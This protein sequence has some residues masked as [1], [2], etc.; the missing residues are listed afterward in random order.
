VVCFGVLGLFSNDLLEGSSGLV[1]VAALEQCDAVGERVALE[2]GAVERPREGERLFHSLGC[3]CRNLCR[4]LCK[5]SWI[6]GALVELH[7]HSGLVDQKRAGQRQIAAPVKKI[8]IKNV[9]DPGDFWCSEQR[10]QVDM[11]PLQKL[12]QRLWSLAVVRM[13]AKH[14]RSRLAPPGSGA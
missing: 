8:A 12:S 7:D 1:E 4:V 5:A 2:P 11:L 14:L 9:I 3:G 13:D 10:W 6:S